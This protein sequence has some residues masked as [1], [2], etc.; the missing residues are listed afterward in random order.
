G[1]EAKTFKVSPNS[2][3]SLSQAMYE[4]KAGDTIELADGFYKR[5]IVS[6]RSGKSDD[7]IVIRGSRGAILRDQDLV[8]DITHNYVH[9]EG[10]TV[11]GR[12]F[13]DD[14]KDSYANKC[15]YV[16][17]EDDPETISYNGHTFESSV[18]GVV[19]NGLK[20]KNCL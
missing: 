12:Y 6:H 2:S 16:H 3:P 4:A 14:E 5:G 19:I 18:N 1:V 20:I 15:V 11:D 7:P 17:G 13:S 10:F 8:V 9:L